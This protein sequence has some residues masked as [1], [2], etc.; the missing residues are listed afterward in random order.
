M[1][2][3]WDGTLAVRTGNGILLHDPAEGG[4]VHDVATFPGVQVA[5]CIPRRVFGIERV[6]EEGNPRFN[7]LDE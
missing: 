1:V 4:D 3:S 6:D 2:R 5:V 7:E